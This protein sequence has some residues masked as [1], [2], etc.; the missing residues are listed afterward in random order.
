MAK[1]RSPLEK[2]DN[3]DRRKSKY[4]SIAAALTEVYGELDW[5]R[6]QDGMDELVS[7]IL[8]QS[9]NDINRDRAFERLKSSYESWHAVRFA[10]IGE[11]T[12]VIRPAGLANQKAPRIQDVLATIHDKAGEYS[13]DFLDELSIEEA[14]D[15]LVSL[16]GIGPKT[17]AIV[18]CFAY[19]RPA[20]PV[21]THIYRV[22]KRIGFIPEKLSANDAH[23]V[24]EAIVPADD[25]YQFH[26]QLIQHGR[27][28]CHARKPA[29]ERCS[30]TRHCD[31]FVGDAPPQP[32]S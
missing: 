29:C 17:A 30:I 2:V 4:G 18:L 27:D 26:I 3:F 28:T 32:S 7:C 20:F 25:Y 8:S 15:W 24:M 5:S 10:E 21:D 14:K 19:G 11:L 1:K 22:S 16:K 9:T 23:P 12:D 13:I 31:Y 6:N